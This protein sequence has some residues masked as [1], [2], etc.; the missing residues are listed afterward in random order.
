MTNHEVTLIIREIGQLR[1]TNK[2]RLYS[3]DAW[4]LFGIYNRIDNAV[5]ITEGQSKYLL[6]LLHRIKEN[7]YRQPN[8]KQMYSMWAKAMENL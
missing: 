2:V 1:F 6:I 4:F 7:T 5:I 3:F 8:P